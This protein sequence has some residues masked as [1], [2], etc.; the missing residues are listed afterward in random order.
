MHAIEHFIGNGRS[1]G[2]V[3]GVFVFHR[4][5]PLCSCFVLVSTGDRFHIAMFPFS[6]QAA[7]TDRSMHMLHQ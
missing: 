1:V 6:S 3:G 5:L 7:I 4:F 2:G